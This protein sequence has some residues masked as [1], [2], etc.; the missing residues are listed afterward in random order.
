M[1]VTFDRAGC[2]WLFGKATTVTVSA[3]RSE[4]MQGRMMK[5][6]KAESICE[7]FMN[8]KRKSIKTQGESMFD[9]EN[10]SF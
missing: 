4:R 6:R 5:E 8:G 10:G 7:C 3:S 1:V 9:E 2:F